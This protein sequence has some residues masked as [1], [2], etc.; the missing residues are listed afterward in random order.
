MTLSRLIARPLLSSVFAVGAVNALRNAPALAET[1]EPVT[2]KI[3]PAAQKAAPQVP[4][5]EDPTTLVRINAGVQLVAAAALATGKLPRLSAAVLGASMV[6]TTLAGHRFWEFEG[7][8]R[9]QH[10]LH[11]FKNAS[12]LGGLI[13]AAGDL[14]GRPGVAWRAKQAAKDARREAKHLAATTRREAKLAKAQ[15]T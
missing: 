13:I 14:E 11:F 12:I 8:E 7:A 9:K 1:A 2:E 6:P 3:V 5:P 10:Q 15:L 4:I